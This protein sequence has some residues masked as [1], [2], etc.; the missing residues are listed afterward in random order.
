MK[1]IE[2]LIGLELVWGPVLK[3]Y[4]LEDGTFSSGSSIVDNDPIINKLDKEVNDL[5]CSLISDDE[6]SHSGIKFDYE[7]EKELAPK[8]L[9]LINQIKE[10]LNEIN[11]GSYYVYDMISRNLKKLL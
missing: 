5:W 1:K 9:D 8:L 10:R 4:E 11:D 6:N 7:R 2:I 3:N